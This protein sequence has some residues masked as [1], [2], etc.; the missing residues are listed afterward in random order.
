MRIAQK[1]CAG[2]GKWKLLLGG[3]LLVLGGGCQSMSNTDRGTLAGGGIGAATG[4]LIGSATH[5]AGAGALLGGAVGAIA[6]GLTG[7]V[8]GP[9]IAHGLGLKGHHRRYVRR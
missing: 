4:A 2:R 9:H 6:G 8:A 7:Y 3:A 1:P 5:H